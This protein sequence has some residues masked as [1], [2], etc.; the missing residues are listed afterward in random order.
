MQ[1]LLMTFAFG[2]KW[3]KTP[4]LS[5]RFTHAAMEE[6]WPVFPAPGQY[7]LRRVKQDGI[8]NAKTVSTTCCCV[9][10]AVSRKRA[11]ELLD[12]DLVHRTSW[13]AFI[14]ELTGTRR[15]FRRT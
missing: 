4:V 12:G 2:F 9:T 8:A 11:R 7:L 3:G 5:G 6:S 10:S 13:L 1:A 15:R 14:D